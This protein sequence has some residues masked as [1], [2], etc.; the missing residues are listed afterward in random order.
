MVK[1]GDLVKQINKIAKEQGL[2]AEYS[3]G[4]RHTKVT[5][6]EKHTTL[7]RHSEV[8]ELT[9]RGILTYLKGEK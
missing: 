4:G 3:E 2:T 7:P 9:A 8:N 6:G 5:L 1:R